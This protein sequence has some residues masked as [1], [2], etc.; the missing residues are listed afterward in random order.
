M[1]FFL[2]TKTVLNLNIHFVIAAESSVMSK[3]K[4]DLAILLF[5][6]KKVY[7]VCVLM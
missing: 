5:V 2:T 3:E 7:I 1:Y 6:G 4:V